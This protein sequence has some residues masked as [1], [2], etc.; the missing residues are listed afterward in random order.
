MKR[1]CKRATTLL[2]LLIALVVLS[3]VLFAFYNIQIFSDFQVV[4]S[5]RKAVLQGEA[6]NVLEHMSKQLKGVVGNGS[7]YP[8]ELDPS[9]NAIRFWVD[10]NSDGRLQNQTESPSDRLVFY[11]H[12]ADGSVIFC[13]NTNTAPYPGSTLS[14][15][16]V[17]ETLG[18]H[19]VSNFNSSYIIINNSTNYVKVTFKCC[20][21][22][23]DQSSCGGVKNPQVSF[24]TQI[25]MPSTSAVP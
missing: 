17:N 18:T 4:T 6:V 2:E 5:N 10:N 19:M 24:T 14:C 22:V 8:V 25:D 15:N 13:N 12:A 16:G 1:E 11:Y 23:T 7:A 21:N 3:M 9:G 20:W